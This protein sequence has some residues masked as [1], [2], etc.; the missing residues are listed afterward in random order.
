MKT[1]AGKGGELSVIDEDQLPF[2]VKRSYWIYNLK[3]D[4]KRG[5]HVHLNSDRVLVCLQGEAEVKLRNK[6]G[7]EWDFVLNNPGSALYFPRQYWIDMSCKQGSILM[8][9]T[10]CGYAEDEL[11]TNWDNFIIS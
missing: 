3:E 2:Q 4:A 1:S 5:G 10:S 7:E 6:K 9:L 8:A 11:E